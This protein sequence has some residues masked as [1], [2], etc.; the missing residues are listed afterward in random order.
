MITCQQ[1]TALVTAY[2]EMRLPFWDRLR[3]QLHLGTCRHCRR[4]LRQMRATIAVMGKLP[5]EPVP[6]PVMQELLARF[7]SWNVQ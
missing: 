2:L 6:E 5:P 3:F 1:I 7:R 4:Y